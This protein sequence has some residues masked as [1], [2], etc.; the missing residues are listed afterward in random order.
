[1]RLAQVAARLGV[2]APAVAQ[3]ERSEADGTIT[4]NTL[5]KV[6]GALGCRMVYTFVPLEAASFEALVEAR[7][8]RVASEMVRGV[9]H[10]MALEDQATNQEIQ[11]E[12]ISDLARDLIRRLPRSLWDESN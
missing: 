11:Q 4:L 8:T 2:S 7:A 9:G 12:E 10:T 6:A 5:E 1:M 3:F